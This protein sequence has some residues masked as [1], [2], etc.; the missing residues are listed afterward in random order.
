LTFKVVGHEIE[1]LI[2]A[3]GAGGTVVS[4]SFF[5]EIL[6]GI[7]EMAHDLLDAMDRVELGELRGIFQIEVRVAG[8][9]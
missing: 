3:G 6:G 4:E 9:H 8:Q 7:P 5:K 1:A 2:V